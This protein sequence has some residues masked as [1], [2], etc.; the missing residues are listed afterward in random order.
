MQVKRFQYF[1]NDYPV[2]YSLKRQKL[3]LKKHA[4][5]T[6]MACENERMVTL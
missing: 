5:S 6:F 4:R 3:P 2:I 1:K